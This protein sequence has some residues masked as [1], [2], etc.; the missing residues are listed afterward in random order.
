M[1]S[2]RLITVAIHTYERAH[3]LKTLLESEGIPVVLHNVNLTNPSISAGIRVR[4]KECDLP[5]ALRVIENI[6]ILSPEATRTLRNTADSLILVPVD[7]SDDSLKAALVAFRIASLL[8]AHIHLLHSYVDPAYG[9][10]SVMQLSDS[11]TFDDADIDPVEEMTLDKDLHRIARE[12]MT[13]FEEKLRDKIRTG[14]IPGVRF[15]SDVIEGLPEE[16]IDDYYSA[17]KNIL[18][19]MGTRGSDS[20][21]RNLVGSVAAEVLDSCRTSVLTVPGATPW[22]A[23]GMP[24]S[25]VFFTTAS[26]DDILALDTL[27]RLFPETSLSV[28][29]IAIPPSRFGKADHSS[30]EPLLKYCRTNYPAYSFKAS[31]LSLSNPVEDFDSIMADHPVDLIAVGSRRK[32]I[33]SRLFNPSLAHRL[34][35]HS[36]IPLLSIPVKA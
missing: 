25:A 3:S 36:D 4:I 9:G 27:Y 20:T 28:T 34:L 30:L 2:D 7:F 8:G 13:K 18:T 22:A 16:A 24:S 1:L 6:E 29:L 23:S 15:T 10:Q 17:N 32:N 19:V 14:V 21:N 12:S 33:F 31:P 26:Q 35:F 11:M 5:Q